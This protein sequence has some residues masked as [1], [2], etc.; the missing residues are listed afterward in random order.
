M[1]ELETNEIETYPNLVEQVHKAVLTAISEGRLRPGARIIQ[2]GVARVL[3]VSR[4]PVQQALLLLKNQGVLLDAPGRGLQVAPLDLGYVRNMYDMRAVVEGLASRRAASLNATRA[5]KEGPAYIQAG[6]DAVAEQSYRK[7][8]VADMALHQFIYDLAEN[9][10]IPVAMDAHWIT[11]QRVMG[12][13][14]NKEEK[15]RN[16]WT[17]HAD[18]LEAIGSGN[19]EQAEKLARLHIS[20]AADFMINCLEESQFSASLKQDQDA[21]VLMAVESDTRDSKRKKLAQIDLAAH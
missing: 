3:G 21:H 14:L 10:L 13:V 20:A 15:P 1:K 7:M 19:E 11:A 2:E 8:I 17:Q 18:I 12:Q 16:I 4:Q 6:M 9:P 5:K